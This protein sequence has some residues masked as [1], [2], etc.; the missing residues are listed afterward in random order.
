VTS[1]KN[2]IENFSLLLGRLLRGDQLEKKKKEIREG[3]L[4]G[5]GLVE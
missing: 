2:Q 1:R 5:R 4:S 3:E